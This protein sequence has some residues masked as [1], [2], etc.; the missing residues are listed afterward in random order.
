MKDT[1]GM[2]IA[3]A[4]VIVMTMVIPIILPLIGAVA[5]GIFIYKLYEDRKSE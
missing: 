3:I 4:G 2:S 1:I 5:V